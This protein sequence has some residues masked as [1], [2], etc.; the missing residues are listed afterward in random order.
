M[1]LRD[2]SQI[3]F[4]SVKSYRKAQ[5]G[6]ASPLCVVHFPPPSSPIRIPDR[7]PSQVPGETL[8][9][10]IS[11]Q[12]AATGTP[13]AETAACF[14]RASTFAGG[15]DANCFLKISHFLLAAS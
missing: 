1:S 8:P 4:F 10:W 13:S 3:A 5:Q 15:L 7:P 11:R 14:T 12:D 9:I 2:P 6:K